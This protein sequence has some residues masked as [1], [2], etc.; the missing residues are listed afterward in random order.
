MRFASEV[1]RENWEIENK[2][3]F[4][5]NEVREVFIGYGLTGAALESVVTSI[6]S[7]RKPEAQPRSLKI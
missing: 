3:E 2:R 4:E 5:L 6:T 7:D 1:S